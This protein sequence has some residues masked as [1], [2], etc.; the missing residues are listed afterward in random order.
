[1]NIKLISFYLSKGILLDI[2]NYGKTLV[3]CSIGLIQELMSLGFNVTHEMV[4]NLSKKD[5]ESSI[6][7]HNGVLDWKINYVSGYSSMR[8]VLFRKFPEDMEKSSIFKKGLIQLRHYVTGHIS[9]DKMTERMPAEITSDKKKPLQILTPMEALDEYMVPKLKSLESLQESEK[10]LMPLILSNSGKTDDELFSLMFKCSSEENRALIRSYLYFN[11]DMLIR[12]ELKPIDVVRTVQAYIGGDPSLYEKIDYPRFSSKEKRVI[13]SMFEAST[14]RPLKNRAERVKRLGIH[15]HYTPD[16]MFDEEEY[17]L[18]LDAKI[19]RA[20][21]NEDYDALNEMSPGKIGRRIYELMNNMDPQK[22][23]SIFYSKV[24]DMPMN[25]LISLLKVTRYPSLTPRVVNINGTREIVSGRENGD[26]IK[27]LYSRIKQILV[28][29][30]S[31]N[32]ESTE[33]NTYYI[34]PALDIVKIPESTRSATKSAFH[35]P[36]GSKI[37]LTDDRIRFFLHW[38]NNDRDSIDMDLSAQLLNSV[39]KSTESVYYGNL[40]STDQ[41]IEHSGDI[42]DA[43][44]GAVEYMDFVLEDIPEDSNT[45]YAMII[46]NS[47]SRHTFENTPELYIGWMT[48]DHINNSSEEKLYDPKTVEQSLELNHEHRNL[49]LCL[50]DRHTKELIWID[51]PTVTHAIN[52][53]SIAS[54]KEMAKRFEIFQNNHLPNQGTLLRQVYNDHP[55]FTEVD[56]PEDADTVWDMQAVHNNKIVELID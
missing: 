21:K 14:K 17:K 56:D 25:V 8:N 9:Y 49:T 53:V 10:E 6:L 46:L 26:I 48:R 22:I 44:K 23:A 45:R 31:E 35:L 39:G 3:R 36:R 4:K 13:K 33:N 2:G 16:W 55:M 37:K 42:T 41:K 18:T 54:E 20:M 29:R 32:L 7:L 52:I 38:K 34:D 50:L 28:Y 30:M 51:N 47:Y 43:P 12:E 15:L 11:K 1:M 19:D 27:P 5:R 24:R 40:F